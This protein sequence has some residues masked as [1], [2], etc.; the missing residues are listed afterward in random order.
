MRTFPYIAL[1][2]VLASGIASAATYTVDFDNDPSYPELGDVNLG[3][4]GVDGW[5]Y[6]VSNPPPEDGSYFP[7]AFIS[8]SFASGKLP[9][10]DSSTPCRRTRSA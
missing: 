5:S 10:A 3:F 7:Y 2:L 1:S 9:S 8:S 6:S 4:E